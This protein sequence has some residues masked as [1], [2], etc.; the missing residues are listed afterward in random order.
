M[1]FFEFLRY[2]C[3]CNESSDKVKDDQ[4]YNKYYQK[5]ETDLT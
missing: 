1:C 2:I 3:C 5:F 4:I